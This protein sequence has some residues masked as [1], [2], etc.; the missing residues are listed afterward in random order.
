MC[1]KTWGG[2]QTPMLLPPEQPLQELTPGHRGCGLCSRRLWRQVRPA[3]WR[4][5]GV[6]RQCG[7]VS[8]TPC[9]ER[10]CGMN[11]KGPFDESRCETRVQPVLSAGP[12]DKVWLRTQTEPPHT[13][14]KASRQRSPPVRSA[15][16]RAA[17]PEQPRWSTQKRPCR[18]PWRAPESYLWEFHLPRA[19]SWERPSHIQMPCVCG[20][21]VRT[22]I[23][24]LQ[25]YKYYV[26][27]TWKILSENGKLSGVA[28]PCNSFL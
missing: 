27:T 1:A 8:P 14:P 21:L 13:P 25:L 28:W 23:T 3:R 16:E 17:G 26:L 6:S 19:C 22:G 5:L 20:G 10:D 12:S 11:L 15:V 4:R 7:K 9:K 18:G 2:A 24:H